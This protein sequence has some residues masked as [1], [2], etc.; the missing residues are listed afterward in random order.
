[1]TLKVKRRLS[2]RFLIIEGSVGDYVLDAKE[3]FCTCPARIFKKTTCKHLREVGAVP[4]ELGEIEKAVR[5]WPSFSAGVNN[6]FGGAFFSSDAVVGLHGLPHEGKSLWMIHEAFNLAAQGCNVLYVD[7]EGNASEMFLH[8]KDKLAARF[9][10]KGKIYLESRRSLE[11]LCDFL[12]FKVAV[13]FH[14]AAKKG[15][16]AEKGKM[17]FRILSSVDESDLEKAVREKEISAVI[18]D[19][20]SAPI[21]NA[22]PDAQENFPSRASAMALLFGKLVAVQ[23]KF[24]CAVAVTAHSSINPANPY[25]AWAELRGGVVAHHYIKRLLYI[26]SRKAKKYANFRRL[27]VFRCEDKPK[28]GGVAAVEIRDDGMHDYEDFTELLSESELGAIASA[29]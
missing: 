27:W 2:Q 4:I 3:Q 24:S 18:I 25:Q 23:E 7:T 11:S 16:Q 8:W 13:V 22:F 26:D 12:G 19:S 5:R 20:I 9:S 14:S 21:R 6:L 1:M 10:P 17:E 28:L 29:E 15:Q